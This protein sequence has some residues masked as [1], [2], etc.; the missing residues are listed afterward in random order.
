[1]W[2]GL[3]I[4]YIPMLP[5]PMLQESTPRGWNKSIDIKTSESTM[6]ESCTGPQFNIEMSS[7]QYRKSHCGDKTVVRSSNL[8]NGISY[9]GK[10]TS[11]YW[12]RAQDSWDYFFCPSST[13]FI[14][15]YI[16]SFLP[17][18]TTWWL[19]ELPHYLFLF[20]PLIGPWELRLWYWIS[21]FQTHIIHG[22][23]N[24][25]S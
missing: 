16:L 5:M 12:I 13:L 7:Y 24:I 17:I 20:V 8:H 10:M 22:I 1:M 2:L 4:S 6:G 14:Y 25:C 21:N 3:G 15:L 18:L 23:L 19:L 11:L 9:T